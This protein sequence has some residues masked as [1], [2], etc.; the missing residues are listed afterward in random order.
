MRAWTSP[1]NSRKSTRDSACTPGNRLEIPR[2]SRMGEPAVMS[3]A[4]VL[5]LGELARGHFGRE[6][7]L[8][9]EDP[10]RQRLASREVLHGRHE[11]RAEKGAALDRAVELSRHHRLEG[12]LHPV[13]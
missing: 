9:C 4:S 10:L 1:G 5:A 8:L 7:A 3:F 2:I 11:R 12:P 6:D 13:D